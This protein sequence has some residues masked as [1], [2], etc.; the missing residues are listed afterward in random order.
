[1]H[2]ITPENL[3]KI[4][5]LQSPDNPD[6]YYRHDGEYCFDSKGSWLDLLK[7]HDE[8]RAEKYSEFIK[9]VKAEIAN[10]NQSTK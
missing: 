1:M 8:A 5:F 9:K 2:L 3:L 4:G 7:N 6:C 10:L